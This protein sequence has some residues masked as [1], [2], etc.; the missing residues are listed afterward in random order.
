MNGTSNG[1]ASYKVADSVTAH[2]AYGLGVY[3]V[4]T[5]AGVVSARAISWRQVLPKHDA[6]AIYGA[7]PKLPHAPWLVP[8][9]LG[10]FRAT[11]AHP[12]K[13]RFGIVDDEISDVRV[14]AELRDRWRVGTLTHHDS[15]LVL[16]KEAPSGIAE[17]PYLETEDARVEGGRARQVGNSQDVHRTGDGH[18]NTSRRVSGLPDDIAVQRPAREEAKRPTRQ[19]VRNDR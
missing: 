14:I 11:F 10:Q 3:A 13:V 15:A 19:S 8:Q 16:H 7:N 6:V 1:W 9:R 4:F 5:N 2:Q 12:I 18:A 17:L